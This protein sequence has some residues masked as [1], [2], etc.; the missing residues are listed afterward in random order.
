MSDLII[1]VE[2]HRS[3][4]KSRRLTLEGIVVGCQPTPRGSFETTV[5]F[6]SPADERVADGMKFI[7]SPN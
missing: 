7:P 6:L 5:L 3:G 1:A 2:W 4:C